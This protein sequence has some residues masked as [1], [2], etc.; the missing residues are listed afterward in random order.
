MLDSY[1][2]DDKVKHIISQLV[3]SYQAVT[4]FKLENV[5]LKYKSRI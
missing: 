3:V 1:D 5:L 4:H 2:K